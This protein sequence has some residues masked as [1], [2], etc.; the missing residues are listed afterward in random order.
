MKALLSFALVLMCS[1]AWGDAAS[2]IPPKHH[3]RPKPLDN[4]V[5]WNNLM[6]VAKHA[7]AKDKDHETRLIPVISEEKLKDNDTC[8]MNAN[9]LD[10][11]L[12]NVLT[13]EG[14]HHKRLPAVKQDLHRVK[15]DLENHASC[16]P[17]K[18]DE[19]EYNQKF[20]KNYRAAGTDAPNKAI[21]EMDILF[22]YLFES[23]N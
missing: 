8:C 4:S 5:T 1:V 10:Y 15:R 17:Q 21:G 9:I 11:Y 12:R 20:R 23:C 14:E 22:H 2:I 6:V 16:D 3:R 7:Q 19:N 18:Y 13:T